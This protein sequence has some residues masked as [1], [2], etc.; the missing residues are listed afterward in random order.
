[1]PATHRPATRRITGIILAGGL[2]RRMGAPGRSVDKG[3]S[4]FRGR[5]M[6]AHVLDRLSSQVDAVLI[7]ANRN[8]DA[9]ARLG[10]HVIRDEVDGFAGPLAGLHAALGQARTEWVLTCP[11]D[12][13]FLPCDLATRLEAAVSETGSPLGVAR[14]QGREQPVFLLAHRSLRAGLDAYLR[15]G[16]AKV[17]RWYAQIDTARADFEDIEAFRNINTAEDLARFEHD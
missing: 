9:Y 13:P 12:T 11:C 1:M 3:L 16:H 14:V 6:V 8:V 15:S 10:P 4:P 2:S 17:D 5:P 7:N